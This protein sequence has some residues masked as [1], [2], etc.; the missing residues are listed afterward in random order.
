M[1]LLFRVDGW[2]VEALSGY[3]FFLEV[4]LST[5]PCMFK[6]HCGLF[7]L[8]TSPVLS[9]YRMIL[10]ISFHFTSSSSVR[11]IPPTITLQVVST[12]F[13]LINRKGQSGNHVFRRPIHLLRLQ[14]RHRNPNSPEALRPHARRLPP[15]L[16]GYSRG[17]CRTHHV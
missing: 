14:N 6:I 12:N 3:C 8:W 4:L 1:T 9:S 10:S 13:T 11:P 5:P 2:I 17:G 15:R 16:R 7:P